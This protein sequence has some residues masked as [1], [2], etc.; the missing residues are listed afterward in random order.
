M[1][2]MLKAWG[3]MTGPVLEVVGVKVGS[4]GGPVMLKQRWTELVRGYL[5]PRSPRYYHID[6]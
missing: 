5:A 6:S 3:P 4:G 2:W 1:T